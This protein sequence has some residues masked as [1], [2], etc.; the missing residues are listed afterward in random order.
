MSTDNVTVHHSIT[1]INPDALTPE[2]LREEFKRLQGETFA[3]DLEIV[4]LKGGVHRLNQLLMFLIKLRM[5]N[6]TPEVLDEIDNMVGYYREQANA[7]AR[8]KH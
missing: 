1:L 4:R 7:A 5:E 3:K 6:R 2:Q 8:T